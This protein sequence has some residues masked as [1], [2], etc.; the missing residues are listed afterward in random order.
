MTGAAARSSWF[1]AGVAIAVAVGLAYASRWI[2]TEQDVYWQ[3][4]AGEE[5]LQTL[6]FP[7]GDEWSFTGRGGPWLNVQW[8]ATL[9]IREAY[10]LAQAWGT[11]G[12]NGLIV[13]RM[14]G[15]GVLVLALA[16]M[17]TRAEAAREERDYEAGLVLAVLLPV[18][19]LATAFRLQI[20][21]DLF[22]FAVFAVQIGV[23][24]LPEPRWTFRRKG[25]ASLLCIVLSANIHH[26]TAP[27]LLASAWVFG[28]S[29]RSNWRYRELLTFLGLSL[30]AFFATPYGVRVIP[31]LVEHFFYYQF[32]MMANPDHQP[33]AW[34]HFDPAEFS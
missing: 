28:I 18:F 19:Y 23:W 34:R 32:N 20:R 4:R 7:D 5:L 17:L 8:I 33:L 9:L 6:R 11:T 30:L 29:T 2:L 12:E 13:A 25:L 26:G 10:V 24:L 21:A 31:F 14:L 27:F 3:I 16:W 15:V 22:V 1:A